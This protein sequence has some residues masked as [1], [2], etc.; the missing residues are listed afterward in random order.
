MAWSR[1]TPQGRRVRRG[2]RGTLAV[3][4]LAAL[5][6]AVP[7]AGARS[8][9][10]NAPN[11]D[12]SY[13]MTPQSVGVNGSN[14]DAKMKDA[15]IPGLLKQAGIGFVRYPGGSQADGFN[16]TATTG[17]LTWPQYETMMSQEGGAPFITLNYGQTAVGGV[18]GP[19]AAA[20]W[21]TNALTTFPNYSDATARWA[22][23]NENYGSWETDQ[24]PDPHTPQSYATN[25]LPYMQALHAADPSAQV[26]VPV[27]IPRDISGGTGTW[28]AD[29]DKWDRT[30]LC[31]D[32]SQVDWAD[33]HWY[34][35]FGI[36]V[37]SNDQLFAT[38]NQIPKA[39]QYVKGIID[40]CDPGTP[41]TI[42]E[43]NI[44]QSEIVYNAQ[45][46]AALYSAAT[47][48]KFLAN[49]ASSYMW[50]QVF[51]SDN[52]NG[53]FGF[54]SD[55]SGTP[56]PSASTLAAD[57]PAGARNISVASSTGF[58]YAHQFTIGSGDVTE[59]RK[60]TSVPGAT[61]LSAPAA[62]GDVNVKIA[63]TGPFTTSGA[64]TEYQ[65]LFAPGTP[66][67][68]GSGAGAETATVAS[69][70]SGATS[71]TL[72]AP[73]AAGDTNVKIV[74]VAMGGQSVPV[75]MPV[76]L[77]EGARLT[78]GTDTATIKSVGTASS[79]GTTTVVP[80]SAGDST[81]YVA[82][83]TNNNTGIANYVGDPI[84]IDAGSNL[85]VGTIKSV[86]VSAA[87]ATTTLAPI[88]AGDTKVYPTSSTGITVGHQFVVDTAGTSE[89]RTVSAVGQAARTASTLSAAAAAG[90]TNVKVAAVTN[91]VA[92]ETIAI[93]SG[94]TLEIGTIASVGTAGATGTGVTL[95][96]PL[97]LAHAS[98]VAARDIG[99]GV[100]VSAPFT[101]AHA[102]GVAARD[103]G[104]GIALTAPLALA[105]ATGA[106]TRDTGS[107]ITLT[108]PLAHAYA[109]G[110]A[111]TSPGTGITLSAP[112]AAA[113]AAGEAATSTGITF[114]PA[115]SKPHVSGEPINEL[116]LKE[117]VADTPMPAYWGY[118]L[119]SHVAV[120]GSQLADLKTPDPRIVAFKS[121]LPGQAENVMLINTDD[122][123]PVTVSL[124]GLQGD[125][126]TAL[127]TYSYS[128]ETPLLNP[129]IA[130]GSTTVGA[131]RTGL[132]LDPQSIVV[133]S[134]AA[135]DISPSLVLSVSTSASGGV[136]GT[137]P[138]ALSL[139]L[140]TPASFGAFTPGLLKDYTA[141]TTANVISTAGD[142][143]LSV[144]D[145]SSTATG[146]LVNGTF[147]LPSAL[148]A[149]ASSAAGTGNAFAD[150]GGAAAPTP[151][152]AYAGP[153]SNDAVTIAF[154]QHIGA[155]DALRTGAYSK[156]LTYTLSTT[157]P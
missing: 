99:L 6:A 92:G 17:N 107:G 31:Q 88:A 4:L 126:G 132:V 139:T 66:V 109:S 34:P 71:A 108:A 61:T 118:V 1:S 130:T 19:Q 68:I 91:M 80:A 48:L 148:Q 16:W 43:S 94:A 122:T 120:P 49:G 44:S 157:T 90:D 67:T 41:V 127:Q 57:A 24:H 153:T 72:A 81:I 74:G 104:T 137:V 30:I 105:H 22:I 119:A 131:V 136:G 156:T 47:T 64:T 3:G 135:G 83:V 36:P 89:T 35:I 154:Q 123:K 115:L 51:N 86:G 62:A 7:A 114:T 78:I 100:T 76:G 15:V 28:V 13:T 145:P 5:A 96:A 101:A 2:L 12:G 52:M 60:I 21:L 113:H 45:P 149:K 65:Q 50:W 58:H 98:G 112:L 151:L 110:S 59:S 46:V 54:L 150:V 124:A 42:G 146:H 29:P 75:W 70:G 129:G 20:N 38:L 82:S 155:T 133:L 103:I 152:L 102:A 56:G 93:G 39:M 85:E 27:T 55:A 87:T 95:G 10:V 26:G 63:S 53:D 141:S 14:S 111:A 8:S 32:A 9:A 79:L 37:L 142:A 84:T 69:A 121:F 138:A 140:G 143:A 33:L 117:P 106:A 125:G 147:S 73:A 18:P 40:A 25:A 128:L 77:V 23:G 11:A 97:A 134:G 144:A 116:G